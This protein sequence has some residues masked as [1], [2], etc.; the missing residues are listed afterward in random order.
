MIAVRVTADIMLP[1]NNAQYPK[2]NHAKAKVA[3]A[4][5]IVHDAFRME[6]KRKRISLA[7]AAPGTP[8]SAPTIRPLQHTMN[9]GAIAGILKN[10]ANGLAIATPSRNNVIA[11]STLRVFICASSSSVRSRSVTTA[12]ANQGRSI[13]KGRA[14]KSRREP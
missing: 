9:T 7:S 2:P 1:N 4:A 10:A 6:R 8:A 11:E 13:A 14:S 3:I 5:N 12:R